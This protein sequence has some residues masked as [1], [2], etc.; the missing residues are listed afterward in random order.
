MVELDLVAGAPELHANAAINLANNCTALGDTEGALEHL[1]RIQATLDQP[2]DPWLRWRYALHLKDALAR[3]ALVLGEPERALM[4]ADEELEGARSH[5]LPKLMA[6]ALELRGRALVAMDLREES[7]RGL[8]EAL[9]L[10]HQIGYPP[11]VWRALSILA[12]L[13][14]RSGERVDAERRAEQARSLAD[15]LSQSLPEEDLR[16]ELRGL[17]QRLVDD[18][19]GA[20]R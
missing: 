10:A 12:E 13:A 7:E 17:A 16:R 4:L 8:R 15:S 1:A 2:G 9:D 5:G 3:V 6:R 20:Y 14:R 18:P 19:L 11:V